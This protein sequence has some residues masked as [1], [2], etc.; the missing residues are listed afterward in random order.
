MPHVLLDVRVE[1]QYEICHLDGSINVPLST[2]EDEI[3][4]IESLSAGEKP[5]YCV[6]RRGVASVEATRILLKIIESY[7]DGKDKCDKSRIHSVYNITGG[8]N[9]YQVEVDD[10]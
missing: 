4:R 9:A 7:A 8:Y 6:C 3:A 10:T 2:V 5:I 1:R